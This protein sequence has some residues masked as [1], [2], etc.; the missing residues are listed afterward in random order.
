[1]SQADTLRWPL[2]VTTIECSRSGCW[3][4]RVFLLCSRWNCLSTGKKESLTGTGVSMGFQLRVQAGGRS[5]AQQLFYGIIVLNNRNLPL[6]SKQ[7]HGIFTCTE[8]ATS[9]CSP[10]PWSFTWNDFFL[11][12]FQRP[13][14]ALWHLCASES[15]HACTDACPNQNPRDR[16]KWGASRRHCF[17]SP[18]PHVI[19]PSLLFWFS[20]FSV[21]QNNNN[22]N[23]TG[24]ERGLLPSSQSRRSFLWLS[25]TLHMLRPENSLP[26]TVLKDKFS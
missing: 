10:S 20:L 12:C 16:Y 13:L 15:G 14:S 11:V 25:S 4:T 18:K 24:P 7:D 23:K 21:I 2:A 19:L 26:S 22:S 9:S 3:V 6:V 17:S 1:M 8:M 5:L